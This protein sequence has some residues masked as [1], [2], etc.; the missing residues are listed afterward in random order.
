MK[1]VLL[2]S[3]LLLLLV[4][5]A[6]TFVIIVRVAIDLYS[7]FTSLSLLF[8]LVLVQDSGSKVPLN[9]ASGS[10]H[11]WLSVQD[12]GSGLKGKDFEFQALRFWASGSPM[13]SGGL[14]V[15]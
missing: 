5:A 6:T 1:S 2:Q 15:S 4:N 12:S 8:L 7:F 14:V 10:M 3:F 13:N 9:G 11:V